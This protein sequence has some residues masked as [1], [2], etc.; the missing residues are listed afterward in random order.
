M[1]CTNAYQCMQKV[2]LCK[3]C[4]SLT[5]EIISLCVSDISPLRL[6]SFYL[7]IFAFHNV[8]LELVLGY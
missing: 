7:V 5:T 3:K 2:S 1:M 8:R 4:I 6:P